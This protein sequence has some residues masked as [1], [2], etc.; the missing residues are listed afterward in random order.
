MLTGC[1]GRGERKEETRFFKNSV[2][3]VLGN[4]RNFAELRGE[5]DGK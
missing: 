4:G 5:G 3:N 2:I 1:G